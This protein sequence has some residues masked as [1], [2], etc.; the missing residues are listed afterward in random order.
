VEG[1]GLP[2]EWQERDHYH[3]RVAWLQPHPDYIG[4]EEEGV[5]F[6]DAEEAQE[7]GMEPTFELD[8][9]P[10]WWISI[11]VESG[12][13]DSL[14]EALSAVKSL[15]K[16]SEF[17]AG[18]LELRRPGAG[19]PERVSKSQRRALIH[20]IMHSRENPHAK[21]DD[22]IVRE[23]FLQ[24]GEHALWAWIEH[25]P[26]REE[27]EATFGAPENPLRSL[28]GR[29]VVLHGLHVDDYEKESPPWREVARGTLELE[30]TTVRVADWS[31]TFKGD[32]EVFGVAFEE[33]SLESEDPE[34]SLSFSAVHQPPAITG[35]SP[36]PSGANREEERD[37]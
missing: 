13:G 26:F 36:A 31:H 19:A 14:E 22:G 5:R 28:V 20:Q 32:E 25:A 11:N 10:G 17:G 29:E 8:V 30:G 33:V 3:F 2:L 18:L 34:M 27:F 24:L 15:L 35:T 23:A 7:E 21:P 1:K 4:L 9:R 16:N 6:V 12:W 37:V